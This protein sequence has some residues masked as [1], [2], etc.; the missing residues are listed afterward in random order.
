MCTR[1]IYIG[2]DNMVITGRSMDW[3]EDV[4]TNL[5]VFPA[6]IPRN[7]E[8]GSNSLMWHSK[9]G[10]VIAAAYEKGSADGMNEKGLV[11][12]SLYLAESDYGEC[13]QSRPNL[14]VSVWVQYVLDNYSTVDE[15]VDALK[16]EPF[17][18]LPILLPSG[19]QATLH[20]AISDATGD[21]AIFEYLLGKLVI[22][23]G[24]QY[25]VMTNSPAYHEQIA[26]ND[27]WKTIGGFT[28]LPGT[29]RASDRF[30]RAS[31]MLEAISKQ[32]VPAY[33][34]GVPH[35]RFQHQAIAQVMS[36]MRAVSVPLGIEVFDQPNLASTIWRVVSDQTNLVYYF[37]MSTRLNSF[38]IDLNKLDFRPS[39]SIK[40][41]SLQSERQYFGECSSKFRKSKPF[42]FLTLSS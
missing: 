3:K 33:I 10:S 7:G 27:Y 25:K 41:L 12:N 21:S 19:D 5:Y 6:G 18:L 22:H 20:L 34:K 1:I 38:W 23:H 31:F 15:A 26:L 4:G 40:K 35:Q 16:E 29:H 17:N 39:A 2:D 13:D 37:D 24:R 14:A 36:I 32:I 9:Y 30:A 42:Q 11:A 28:F 8:A